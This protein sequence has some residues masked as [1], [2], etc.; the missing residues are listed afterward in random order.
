MK[1]IIVAG[2]GVAAFESAS[3][4]RKT[5]ADAEIIIYSKELVLPYRRPALSALAAGD[6]APSG[7]F[8]IK[9]SC[10]YSD[11]SI[12][13]KNGSSVEKI[14][15]SDHTVE[16]SDGSVVSYDKLII[17][18][19]ATARRI[20]VPGADGANTF[21]LRDYQ[22][23]VSMRKLIAGRKLRCAIIGGGLLGLELADSLLARG[24]KVT[25]IESASRLLPR[26]LDEEGSRF[27]L[28]RISKVNDLEILSGK[29]VSAVTLDGVV[30][31]SGV[32]ECDLVAFS[33]GSSAFVPECAGL[34]V[35]RGIIADKYMRTNLP[36]IWTAGDCSEI[37]GV[38][39]GLYT[40]ASAMGKVAG[41]C[42]AGGDAEYKEAVCPARLNAFEL[43]LFSAGLLDDHLQSQ[44]TS[45]GD[46]YSRV[47][48]HEDGRVAG[49]VLIGNVSAGTK[50]LKMLE[51]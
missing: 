36:D 37:N 40:M 44:V 51:A 21:V 14:F 8:F 22:D 48:Y 28:E 23:L 42:A 19:G 9:D 5:D 4:A 30:L 29:K 13:V 45:N 25:V 7:T 3:A 18:T 41:V 32:V 39:C 16:L 10:F 49:V 15:S 33:A 35:N 27:L 26:N 1:R 2:G 20:P 34:A 31:D 6:D 12:T 11:N 43:K 17:A 47:F 24:C 46:D 50:Y 38:V